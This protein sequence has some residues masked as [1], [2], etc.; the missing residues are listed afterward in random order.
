M[1]KIRLIPLLLI[2]L[3]ISCTST[4][5]LQGV[6]KTIEQEKPLTQ[7]ETANGLKEALTQGIK[8]GADQVS[9]TDGYFKNTMIK[10]L[11]PP[12]AKKVE[13]KLRDLGLGNEVDKVILSLN[14]AAENAAKEA[15]PIFVNAIKQMTIKDAI[16]ILKGPNDAATQYLK[17]NTSQQLKAKFKPVIQQSLDQVNATKYW[18]NVMNIY[19]KIPFVEKINPD[20]PDYVTRK[21]L[22]GLFHT[23][24][25]EEA[26]IRENPIA[27]ITALLKRVFGYYSK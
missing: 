19:N 24:A 6:Q 7:Q 21:A 14:R 5:I 8:K 4:E 27:R 3:F 20:L 1:L 13:Q 2:P 12:D 17:A 22:D 23:I 11:F 10:I 25:N 26:R 9:V 15:K 18:A 16:N